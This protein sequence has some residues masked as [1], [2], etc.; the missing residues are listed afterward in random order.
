MLKSLGSD[1]TV[2][3][4][5]RYS[6]LHE[7]FLK[8][9]IIH[10]NEQCLMYQ[11]SCCVRVVVAPS[12][13]LLA[14]L[15]LKWPMPSKTYAFNHRQSEHVVIYKS[16]CCDKTVHTV[17]I[18]LLTCLHSYRP[19]HLQAAPPHQCVYTKAGYRLFNRRLTLTL[20]LSKEVS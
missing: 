9:Y 3:V 4:A 7:L 2:N 10:F 1:F 6:F 20:T 19:L 15:A 17:F 14:E 8:I 5:N 13:P 11:G 18:T 16:F 12:L